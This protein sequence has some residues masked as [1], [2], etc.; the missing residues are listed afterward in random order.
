MSPMVPKAF[1]RPISFPAVEYLGKIGMCESRLS[2][3]DALAKIPARL[4]GSL[5]RAMI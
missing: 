3:T 5:K 1:F 2:T 4:C